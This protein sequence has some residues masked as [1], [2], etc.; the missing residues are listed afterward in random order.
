MK[1]DYASD[2]RLSEEEFNGIVT[3]ISDEAV[4]VA[5]D[6]LLFRDTLDDLNQ[7]GKSVALIKV[8]NKVTY[9]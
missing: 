1:L 8:A 7:H 6:S 4:T 9:E 3:K 2:K 5:F